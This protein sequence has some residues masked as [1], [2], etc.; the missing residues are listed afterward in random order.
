MREYTQ[1]SQRFFM[2]HTWPTFLR[3]TDAESQSKIAVVLMKLKVG[4]AHD[5]LIPAGCCSALRYVYPVIFTCNLK[6]VFRVVLVVWQKM[7]ACFAF[8]LFH[9]IWTL[10][11]SRFMSRPISPDDDK[12]WR[13]QTISDHATGRVLGGLNPHCPRPLCRPKL[14]SALWTLRTSRV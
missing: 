14:S 6:V 3:L 7:T 10:Y 2:K 12:H 5:T 8:T 1:E 11:V 9:S 4:H 13:R